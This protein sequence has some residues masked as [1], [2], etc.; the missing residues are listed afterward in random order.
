MASVAAERTVDPWKDLDWIDARAPRT[1][2]AVV[3]LLSIAAIA[4][5][6]QW[7]VA[8]IAFQLVIG[9][10]FCRRFCLACYLYFT[11]I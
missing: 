7:L 9:L 5:G 6:L 1:N 3:A 10:I 8:L 2:H 4:T 11:V